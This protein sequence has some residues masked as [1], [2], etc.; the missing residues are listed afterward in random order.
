MKMNQSQ[1]SSSPFDFGTPAGNAA[2]PGA[3]DK[4]KPKGERRGPKQGPLRKRAQDKPEPEAPPKS[5]GVIKESSFGFRKTRKQLAE[6]PLAESQSQSL[7]SHSPQEADLGPQYGYDRN[8]FAH[9][10]EVSAYSAQMKARYAM[11][12]RKRALIIMGV[13]VVVCALVFVILPTGWLTE[14][15]MRRGLAGWIEALQ[16]NLRAASNALSGVPDGNGLTIIFWRTLALVLVGA[17]LA[18]NGAVYQGALKNALASP[19]TLGVMSGGTL[20]SVIYTLVFG[21]GAVAASGVTSVA[22]EEVA[23]NMASLTTVDYIMATQ[24]RAF[25]SLAGCFVIVGLVLLIA[26]I[27]G[28]GKVSKA[29]LVIAGQVFAAVISGIVSVIRNY[30]TYF[31]TEEQIQAMRTTV[32]GSIDSIMGPLEFLLIAVPLAIG[33]IYVFC[34]SSR[35]NLLAFN[36]EEAKSMGISVGMT[37]NSVILVCTVMTAVVVSFCGNVG[38]VGFLVPHLARKMVGPDLRFLIPASALVGSLYLLVSNYVMQMGNLL[39]G[40]LGS[41]TSI[42]GTIFFLVAIIQQRRRGNVDWI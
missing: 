22:N 3:Q 18:V 25:F 35:L 5:Q 26:Y 42:I 21:T 14:E 9:Q 15:G 4:E 34:M 16:M 7:F 31:G 8:P 10:N 28:K 39:S 33:L 27:A 20:G 12:P 29:A 37:R 23:A 24:L 11:D 32:N 17:T 41:F 38:F 36:D 30:I 2:V 13:M 6:D 40:S 1:E 19:S